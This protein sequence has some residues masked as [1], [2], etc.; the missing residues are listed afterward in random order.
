MLLPC[1]TPLPLKT[2][3]YR[4][5]PSIPITV[6]PCNGDDEDSNDD[7]DDDDDVDVDVDD[8]DDNDIV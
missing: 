8:D 6:Q 4:G 7:D 5:I 1:S 2:C 3:R